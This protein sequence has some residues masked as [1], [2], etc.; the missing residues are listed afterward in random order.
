MKPPQ[1]LV[2]AMICEL[3]AASRVAAAH[4]VS[5]ETVMARPGTTG[6]LVGEVDR[7]FIRRLRVDDHRFRRVR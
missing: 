1:M 6:E 5:S 4:G 3:R 7:M 2:N